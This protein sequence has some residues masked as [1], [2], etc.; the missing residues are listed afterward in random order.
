MIKLVQ[1]VRRL[2]RL[3]V[4]EFRD[5]WE[6]YGEKLRT[7]A[8]ELGA[9][10]ASLSTTL[11]TPLNAAFREA[12][13]TEEPYDGVAEIVWASGTRALADAD[14]P[15]A[16]RRIGELRAD[17]ERFLDLPRCAVFFVH[18]SDVLDDGAR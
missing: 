18:E 17:Q 13:N 10:R 14:Q 5:A 2:P 6:A 8:L 7:L 1:C 4:L 12:R 11:E 16:R 9:S 3:S 15:A